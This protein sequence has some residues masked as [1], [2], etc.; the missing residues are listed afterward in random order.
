MEYKILSSKIGFFPPLESYRACLITAN[1]NGFLH[2]T[3]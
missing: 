2:A 3:C 1:E